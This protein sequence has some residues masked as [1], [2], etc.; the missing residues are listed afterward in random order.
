MERIE[1]VGINLNYKD[2][3][4][5]F[6][7]YTRNAEERRLREYLFADDGALIASMS[8]GAEGPVVYRIS[9]NRY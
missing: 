3:K 5:L 6:R 2:D 4:K 9:V 8:L 7:R 1:G